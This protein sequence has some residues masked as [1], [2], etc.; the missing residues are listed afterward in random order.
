MSDVKICL[1]ELVYS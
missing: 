1:T